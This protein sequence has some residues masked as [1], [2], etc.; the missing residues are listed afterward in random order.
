[1]IGVRLSLFGHPF[2]SFSFQYELHRDVQLKANDFRVTD[3]KIDV[4]RLRLDYPLIKDDVG[5]MVGFAS[6]GHLSRQLYG[7]RYC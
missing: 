4:I 3:H 2:E 5:Q 1:M 6:V 7:E